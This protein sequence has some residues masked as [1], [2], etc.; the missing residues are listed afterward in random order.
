MLALLV[1]A[2]WAFTA[3]SALAASPHQKGHSGVGALF[4]VPIFFFTLMLASTVA[5][6]SGAH[7]PARVFATGAALTMAS[8]VNVRERVVS[9]VS[10]YQLCGMLLFTTAAV[11]T[12]DALELG[13]ATELLNIAMVLFLVQSTVS[14]SPKAP[15]Y[16]TRALNPGYALAATITFFFTMFVIAIIFFMFFAVF[17]FFL[18]SEVSYSALTT[19]TVFKTHST[20][21]IFLFAIALKLA[22]A[23]LHLWKLEVFSATTYSYMFF[24][25]SVYFFYFLFLLR[26]LHT[27]L[28]PLS[29][30]AP[31]GAAALIIL[32]TLG[33]V[34]LNVGAVVDT[35]HFIIVSTLLNSAV[36]LITIFLTGGARQDFF[37]I[38]FLNYLLS[39]LSIFLFLATAPGANRFVSSLRVPRNT[40]TAAA[41]VLIPVLALA[42]A[43]PSLGFL[44]KFMLVFSC[45][46]ADYLAVFSS[47]SAAILFTVVFY[48]QIFK[49]LFSTGGRPRFR[50]RLSYSEGAIGSGVA[51]VVGG[52]AALS[53]VS[54]LYSILAAAPGAAF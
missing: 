40:V 30:G 7:A 24:Y 33:F 23:P 54:I 34:A 48:F 43:A 22:G 4:W 29:A 32:F 12:A 5:V 8:Y 45:W 20:F 49:N 52:G 39:S 27:R 36:L 10:A 35:R 31:L 21:S 38:I 14:G 51:V 25:S 47:L 6:D 46:S 42:G 19:V 18:N 44:A 53:S 41:G 17:I 3:S 15:L 1:S 13:V 26:A 50:G 16:S 28:E 2:T 37:F 11:A 9:P